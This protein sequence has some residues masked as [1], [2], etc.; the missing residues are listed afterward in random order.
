M[1]GDG[2]LTE[3]H[4]GVGRVP[5]QRIASNS[6][7]RRDSVRKR[8]QEGRWKQAEPNPGFI[9]QPRQRCAESGRRA[10]DERQRRWRRVQEKEEKGE[11]RLR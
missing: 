4:H 1:E 2:S 5:R 11:A 8:V 6:I 10:H 3:A 9:S 7:S